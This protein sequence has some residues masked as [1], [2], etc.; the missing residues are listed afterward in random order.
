MAV[1]TVWDNPAY[2]WQPSG[3]GP[4]Y[5]NDAA[6]WEKAN[7][8]DATGH[9]P[10]S[11]QAA[12]FDAGGTVRIPAATAASPFVEGSMFV[13]R[14]GNFPRGDKL[15]VD[16]SGTYWLKQ[17]NP[18]DTIQTANYLNLVDFGGYFWG[19]EGGHDPNNA[20]AATEFLATNVVIEIERAGADGEDG[21]TLTLKQGFLNFYDP[22]GRTDHSHTFNIGHTFG[23][24]AQVIYEEGTHTRTRELT[25]RNHGLGS[26]FWVKGGLHEVFNNLRLGWTSHANPVT[27]RISGGT[28]DVQ[29]GWIIIGSPDK[30][31]DAT[32][33]GRLV[34]DGTGSLCHT[35]NN[36]T[37]IG[38]GVNGTEGYLEMSG[39]SS[40]TASQVHLGARVG[41]RG[42]WSMSGDASATV[43]NHLYVGKTNDSDGLLDISGGM[44]TFGP[45]SVLVCGDAS[46]A[47]ARVSMTGGKIVAN[48]GVWFGNAQY[49]TNTLS[50]TGGE[51]QS[52]GD[53]HFHRAGHAVGD[54]RIG[55]DAKF[56]VASG[57][58]TYLSNASNTDT[59]LV[60]GDDA[61]VSSKFWFGNTSL[62]H[63]DSRLIVTNNATL[64]WRGEW[65]GLSSDSTN[66]LVVTDNATLEVHDDIKLGWADDADSLSEFV[67]D[68]NAAITGPESTKRIQIGDNWAKNCNARVLLR[69]GRSSAP[70]LGIEFSGATNGLV[71][72]SGGDHVFRNLFIYDRN[73]NDDT[74]TVR[75]TGGSVRFN[76]WTVIGNNNEQG[77]LEVSGGKFSTRE[78]NL[79]FGNTPAGMM[80]VMAVSGGEVE[81]DNKNGADS[82]FQ[83]GNN[84]GNSSCARLEQTGG[85]IHAH[86]IRSN[87]SAAGRSEAFFDGGKVVQSVKVHG[88]YGLIQGLT[89]AEVGTTGLT[90]DANGFNAWLNQEFTDADDG[91]GGTVD[92]V[93]RITG[94]GS[95]DI[96]KNSY[97]AKTV[98]DGGRM[99]F[100]NGATV[101][102]RTV[103]LVNGGVYSLEGDA[104]S[105][106]F[107]HLVIGDATSAGVLKLDQGDTI[108]ITGAD[109]LEVNNLVLDVSHMTANGTYAVFQTSGGGT[110][111]PTQLGNVTLKVADP[112][113][114]YTLNADGTVTVADRVFT[115][116]AWRGATSTDWGTAANWSPET[117]PGAGAKAVFDSAGTKTVAVGN[118]YTAQADAL[119][120]TAAGYAIGGEGSITG[121]SIVEN[122][123]Q[124]RVA[125]SAPLTL[126]RT[127]YLQGTTGSDTELAS[128]MSAASAV[129]IK[130]NGSDKA[131]ITGDN[132][133]LQAEWTINGGTLAFDKAV[134]FGG[135][136]KV[137]LESGTLAY[138]GTGDAEVVGALVVDT[139]AAKRG[140]IVDVVSSG[141]LVFTNAH[142]ESGSLVKKG[143]GT[144]KFDFG[145]GEFKIADETVRWDNP[146]TDIAF[147]PSGDS[148]ASTDMF[149]NLSVVDGR[150]VIEGAGSNATKV[151]HRNGFAVGERYADK[152]AEAELV[153]KNVYLDNSLS[154]FSIG[155]VAKS[156]AFNKPNVQVTDGTYLFANSVI[157]GWGSAV[158]TVS[159]LAVTNSTVYCNDWVRLAEN[160]NSTA[161]V[162]VGPGGKIRARN[163]IDIRGGLDVLVE[164]EG[165]EMTAENNNGHDDRWTWD[166]ILRF[167]DQR[168]RG[169]MA[170]KNGGRLSLASRIH[171]ANFRTD[172]SAN[173]PGARL[174][175]D[176]GTLHL[177]SNGTSIM[178]K[179]QYQGVWTEGDGMTFSVA[180]GAVSTWTIPIR[181]DGG[182]VKT[183][184]GE[185][186]FA[187]VR[188]MTNW[189]Y[190]TVDGVNYFD[191]QYNETDMPN[192][193]YEGV[194]EVREGKLTLTA[195]SITNTAVVTVGPSG[196]LD[197][198]G[199]SIAFE[200]IGGSGTVANGTLS[201]AFEPEFDDEGEAVALT[202]SN[203]ELSAG[204]VLLPEDMPFGKTCSIAKLE[205]DS[206]VDVSGMKAKAGDKRTHAAFAVTGGYLTVTRLKPPPL[207]IIVR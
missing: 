14:V 76:D 150:M 135:V 51:V 128:P 187:G 175:F 11:F 125:V 151:V 171:G 63:S 80:C 30:T 136:A 4:H 152:V 66:R 68:G 191:Y 62:T 106:S 57:K 75:V 59:E 55:G 134:A 54:Y 205:S 166:G 78:I 98:V 179:P 124:G 93:V 39:N 202:L 2:K 107:D 173:W 170:F 183:G 27:M 199:N 22:L 113:K 7:E 142:V 180:A 165:A 36:T 194:T 168:G 190:K 43:N 82:W 20:A 41:S 44:L 178:C 29:S 160:E 154:T 156:T 146:G 52:M 73:I 61:E 100:S 40:F 81:V 139:G 130:K 5:W 34:M 112:Y 87:H 185:L 95:V 143:A 200:K 132:A 28:V 26:L 195:G 99:S 97:H 71:E 111:D 91:N 148:P 184:A 114:S 138:D 37:Y 192:G 50:M 24:N 102:G 172:G 86:S 60:I 164:G 182:L 90:V 1:E 6:N 159:G 83:L 89:K 196:T 46:N 64:G 193:W 23:A 96:R 84:G 88:S 16:G 13:P 153:L 155:R 188:D 25:V 162:R 169:V 133:N 79:G 65:I 145:A 109:G 8:D 158:Q 127:L 177:G 72:V 186:V 161:K 33:V 48:N 47:H 129:E 10:T 189:P 103:Q 117:V 147:E 101:F 207:T 201:A 110:I 116:L 120:F 21:A 38:W 121:V 32:P 70:N 12:L 149:N 19:G 18:N 198:G 42:F 174:V 31:N 94:N 85:E 74:N 141:A 203:V 56:T 204:T 115:E 126:G 176:G 53:V 119:L 140:A 197:L 92:G 108:T 58:T 49:S 15:V 9:Q 123:S 206:T 118:G 163:S 69:G 67:L 105:F 137:E 3:D 144:L 104:T 167:E 157:V 131:S 45:N 122:E 181:G 35:N 77:R 17:A